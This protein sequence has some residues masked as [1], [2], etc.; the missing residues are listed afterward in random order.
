MKFTATLLTESHDAT[1]VAKALSADNHGVE[2]LTVETSAKNGM[3]RSIVASDRLGTLVSS[4]DDLIR[5]QMVA[6]E[7][8]SG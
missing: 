3:V 4:V 6:E 2:G 8:F 7:A 1:S 5:C